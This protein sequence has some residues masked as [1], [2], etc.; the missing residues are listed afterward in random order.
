MKMEESSIQSS[1]R[2]RMDDSTSVKTRR[3][4]W[5]VEEDELLTTLVKK[6]GTKKWATVAELVPGRIGKQ[7]RERWLNHLRTD[8]LKTAWTYEEDVTLVNAQHELGNRWSAIAKLLPGRPE[9][10]V[11]NRWNSL[12]NK[13]KRGTDDPESA[14]LSL[15]DLSSGECSEGSSFEDSTVTDKNGRIQTRSP[16]RI[17]REFTPDDG[18]FSSAL[19]DAP[20]FAVLPVLTPK[21]G[22]PQSSSF[23]MKGAPVPWNPQQMVPCMPSQHQA[24]MYSMMSGLPA[25]PRLFHNVLRSNVA[26]LP[27]VST[28]IVSPKSSQK[29]DDSKGA[30][31]GLMLLAALCT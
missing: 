19:A 13:K 20:S 3:G 8:V 14:N 22:S 4:P 7:C 30:A 18:V 2:M 31:Q 23:S 1:K 28:Y 12:V 5:T 21:T 25:Q 10:S 16:A 26:P 11:K 27:S 6:H 15:D 24:L 17:S 29:Q 9:N